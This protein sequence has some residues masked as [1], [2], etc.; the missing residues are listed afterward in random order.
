M[1]KESDKIILFT[2]I[3]YPGYGGAATNTYALIKYFLNSGFKTYGIFFV[4]SEVN[5]DPDNLGN[6]IKLPHIPKQNNGNEILLIKYKN[7]LNNL[8]KKDPDIILNKDY[9]TPVYSHMLYPKIKNIYLVAGIPYFNIY[10]QLSVNSIL[11]S[12]HLHKTMK[13]FKEELLAIESSD[14]IVTNSELTLNIF[15]KIYQNNKEVTKKI[16]PNPIDT[17]KHI[18][19]LINNTVSV[20]NKEYDFLIVASLLDR[21][22]KNNIF[23][24]NILKDIKFNKYT[25]I[26]IG[27]NNSLFRSIPNVIVHDILPHNK[28]MDIMAKSKVLLYPSLF[29][30]NPNSVREALQNKCLILLSNNVGF[31]ERFPKFSVCYTFEKNE[32][33]KKSLYLVANYYKLITKYYISYDLKEDMLDFINKIM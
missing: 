4:D 27:K 26:V 7:I 30:S 10:P 18:T 2:S 24:I 9:I 33:I 23:L 19:C 5:V 31:Q 11:K 22:E 13:L 17:S 8:I 6:I 3:D 25:K 1:K 21:K 28:V 32:W 15:K 29:D 20:Q 14:L 12:N 16:Y